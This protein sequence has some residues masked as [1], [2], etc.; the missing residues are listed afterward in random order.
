MGEAALDAHHQRFR[1]LVA[2]HDALKGT[3]RHFNPL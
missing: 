3:L 1:L 2:H